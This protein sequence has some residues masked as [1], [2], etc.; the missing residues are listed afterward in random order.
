MG[1]RTSCELTGDMLVVR[2]YVDMICRSDHVG[3][4]H[5][6]KSPSR[7][8]VFTYAFCRSTLMVG[9]PIYEWPT[10]FWCVAVKVA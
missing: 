8:N 3:V 1:R 4:V 10:C 5:Y 9:G 2:M 7:D 6:T